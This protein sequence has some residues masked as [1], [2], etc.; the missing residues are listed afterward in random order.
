MTTY[1]KRTVTAVSEVMTLQ[2]AYRHC[3]V[4]GYG[5][6]PPHEDDALIADLI[7][8]A[9]QHAEN[10]T[11]RAFIASTYEQR[12]DYLA[13][14]LPL[15]VL[16][17]RAV[18]SVEYV[19]QD[20]VVQTLDPTLYVFDDNPTAPTIRRAYQA[21]YPATRGE[22]GAVRIHYTAGPTDGTSPD[23]D[24]LPRTAYQA[25]AL[26]LASLYEHREDTV[27]GTTAT[28]LPLGAAALLRPLRVSIL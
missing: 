9:R 18:S 6:S 24:P 4:D 23:D 14:V 28:E 16:P 21:I 10:F 13:D 3:R 1:L 5:E 26:I 15:K 17:V 27:V 20:G 12:A 22:V 25:M 2:E 11:G 19:D 8:A 7:P